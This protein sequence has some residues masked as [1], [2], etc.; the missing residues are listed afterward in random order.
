VQNTNPAELISSYYE[1]PREYAPHPSDLPAVFLAGI[2]PGF[3]N[4]RAYAIEKLRADGPPMLIFNPRREDFPAGDPLAGD[5]QL[6]WEQ[7]H[8]AMAAVTLFWIPDSAPMVNFQPTTLMELGQALAL[9]RPVVVGVDPAYKAAAS[10]RAFTR[11]H[12]PDDPV[13]ASLDEVVAATVD[14]LRAL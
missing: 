6:D 10:V 1:S 11:Y 9:N 5:Q 3:K 14:E 8:L 12:R 2:I 7:R 13:Y 4:W